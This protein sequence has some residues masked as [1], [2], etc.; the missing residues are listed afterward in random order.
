MKVEK[1]G[2]SVCSTDHIVRLTEATFPWAYPYEVFDPLIQAISYMK[3]FVD[4]QTR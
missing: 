4:A 2:L 1:D 3:G